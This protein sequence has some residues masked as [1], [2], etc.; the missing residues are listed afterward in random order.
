MLYEMKS[1]IFQ[2]R[3]CVYARLS[4]LLT[5]HLT[6]FIKKRIDMRGVVQHQASTSE[7][8]E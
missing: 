2:A 3:V 1:E 4:V 6:L 5:A 8:S 7:L